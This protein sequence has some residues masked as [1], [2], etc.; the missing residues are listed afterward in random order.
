MVF[1]REELVAY[2]GGKPRSAEYFLRHYAWHRNLT[3]ITGEL[4]RAP[5][6]PKVPPYLIAGRMTTDAVVSHHSALCFWTGN[7]EVQPRF[8]YTAKFPK[9]R[10]VYEGTEFIGISTPKRLQLAGQAKF[11]IFEHETKG[12]TF[13]ITD[14]ERTLVDALDQPEPNS[15][16]KA[17]WEMLR[18]LKGIKFDMDLVLKY[19]RLLDNAT[20]AAKVGHYL[21]EHRDQHR[22]T[23]V[24]INKVV[25]LIPKHPCYANRSKRCGKTFLKKWNLIIE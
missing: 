20:T 9:R 3:K 24:Q 25:E 19:L 15:C 21:D 13:R 14:A 10:F 7:C 6:I 22:L 16:W 5:A 4:Y 2:L 12:T 17:T 1:R 18:H 8:Y 11:G 23:E